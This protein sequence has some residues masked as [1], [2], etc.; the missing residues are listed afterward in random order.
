MD[1]RLCSA[2]YDRTVRVWDGITEDCKQVRLLFVL[3]KKYLFCN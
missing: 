1:G 2:A 3:S